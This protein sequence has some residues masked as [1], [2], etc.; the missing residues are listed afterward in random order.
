MRHYK[1]KLFIIATLPRVLLLAFPRCISGSV[2]II[3][4]FVPA[5]F[6][7]ASRWYSRTT[8]TRKQLSQQEQDGG[9]SYQSH[10]RCGD[11]YDTNPAIF[12]PRPWPRR[13]RLE[14]RHRSSSCHTRTPPRMLQQCNRRCD[15]EILEV[16]SKSIPMPPTSVRSLTKWITTSR[17]TIAAPTNHEMDDDTEKTSPK[18]GRDDMIPEGI[19]R[20]MQPL[21]RG[22]ERKGEGQLDRKCYTAASVRSRSASRHAAAGNRCDT[23]ERGTAVGTC[24]S[25]ARPSRVVCAWPAPPGRFGVVVVTAVVGV[26][27]LPPIDPAAISISRAW[28]LSPYAY[29]WVRTVAY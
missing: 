16:R 17:R 14:W 20:P 28:D 24:A 10:Q 23:H 3:N 9:C 4:H 15:G 19:S 7:K 11:I 22:A 12:R 27:D 1:P 21:C 6:I 13:C 8:R 5:R 2:A 29:Q 25:E 18:T 26:A